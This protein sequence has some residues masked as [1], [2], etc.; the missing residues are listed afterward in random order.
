MTT[1]GQAGSLAEQF[2]GMQTIQ[3]VRP[4]R[5]AFVD[6]HPTLLKGLAAIFAADPRYTIVATGG[7]AEEALAIVRERSPEIVILDLSMPG[8]VFTT[9]EAITAEAPDCKVVVFTAFANVELGLKS[10]D[11]GVHAFV[12]KGSPS[13]DLFD[14]IE[15]VQRGE[16]YVSPEFSQRLMAGFRKRGRQEPSA[17]VKL[18][19]RE[20]QLVDCLLQGKTNKEI[21]RT[22]QLTEKTVKHYMTNLMSKLQVKNRLEVVL[23][24]QTLQ[25]R[26]S[27]F[28]FEPRDS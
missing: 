25:R 27:G 21:A 4:V 2:S 16:L 23:A 20:Q 8:D 14:A 12:L 26:S 10:L 13:E 22:L 28:E 5:L 7:T 1:G 19:A 9:I 6:D 11:A 17:P 18:S 3:S 15:A 24:A